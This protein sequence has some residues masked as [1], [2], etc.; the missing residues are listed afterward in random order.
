M[1]TLVSPLS[2]RSAIRLATFL[3]EVFL[4]SDAPIVGIIYKQTDGRSASF[5]RSRWDD[6][7]KVQ[8]SF[9]KTKPKRY[10]CGFA[11]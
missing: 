10:D 3:G 8:K 7:I 1:P 4:L 6:E 5:I 9:V 11:S 2:F